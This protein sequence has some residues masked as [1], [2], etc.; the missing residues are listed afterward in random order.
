MKLSLFDIVKAKYLV[1]ENAAKTWLFIIFIIVMCLF[2]IGNI[3]LY[4]GKNFQI[5]ALNHE[6]KELRTEFIQTRSELME[7]KMESSISA[8]MEEKE[9]FPSEVPPQKI[10]VEKKV[11]ENIWTR[12][13]Q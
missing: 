8:K 13:W 4:E 11:N 1:D 10:K 7:M 2:M 6:I 5:E 3:H 9:I 12:I